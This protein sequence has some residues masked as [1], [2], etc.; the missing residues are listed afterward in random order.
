MNRRNFKASLQIL[1][2]DAYKTSL[3]TFSLS[4]SPLSFFLL[5]STI[6]SLRETYVASC[7][8]GNIYYRYIPTIYYH[9]DQN[10]YQ[11]FTANKLVNKNVQIL[12]I[13]RIRKQ[14][15]ASSKAPR[16]RQSTA[17]SPESMP[18]TTVTSSRVES[19]HS[20]HDVGSIYRLTAPMYQNIL[21][22]FSLLTLK[23]V[24]LISY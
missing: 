7:I 23:V 16:V 11:V 10:N 12:S 2:V 9:H 17:W 15:W 21:T 8:T 19:R 20:L 24:K 18:V 14:V 5:L 1:R 6:F 3:I 22:R 13:T 4:P